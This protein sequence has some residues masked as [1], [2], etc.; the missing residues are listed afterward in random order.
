MAEAALQT[1][2]LHDRHLALGAKMVPFGGFDMPIQ[3][4]GIVAEHRAVRQSAG[5]FDVSHMGEFRVTGPDA[6]ALAQ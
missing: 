4:E 3:Y 2:P 1:T 5:L 6:L